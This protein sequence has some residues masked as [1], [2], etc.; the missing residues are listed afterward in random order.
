LTKKPLFGQP[1]LVITRRKK[2]N[3]IIIIFIGDISVCTGCHSGNR[4]TKRVVSVLREQGV[5]TP[6]S[7]KLQVASGN[8]RLKKIPALARSGF[9]GKWRISLPGRR[10]DFPRIINHVEDKNERMY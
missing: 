7:P 10:I 1:H 6:A 9:A 4:Q 8:K 2:E 3:D 5:S